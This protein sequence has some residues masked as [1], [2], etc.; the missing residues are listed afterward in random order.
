MLAAF[1]GATGRTDTGARTGEKAGRATGAAAA[2]AAPPWD[3]CA[4]D[5]VM[6]REPHP[7]QVTM[8]SGVASGPMGVLQRGQFM[9]GSVGPM[10][11]EPEPRV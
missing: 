2:G 8:L 1:G 7:G 10:E 9:G 3:R 11:A 5:R 4:A 6:S